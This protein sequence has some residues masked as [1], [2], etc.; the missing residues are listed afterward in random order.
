VLSN[1]EL[2]ALVCIGLQPFLVLEKTAKRRLVTPAGMPNGL[3]T[4]GESLRACRLEVK[5]ASNPQQTSASSY[6]KYSAQG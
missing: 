1:K 5:W 6:E 4:P 3:W 2:L